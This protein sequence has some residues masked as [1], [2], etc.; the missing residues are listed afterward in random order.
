M[1]DL[2]FGRLAVQRGIITADQL[3]EALARRSERP[4][5]DLPTVLQQMKAIDGRTITMLLADIG[6]VASASA[7]GAAT[8]DPGTP[9]PEEARRAMGVPG[10]HLGRFVLEG[11]LGQGGMGVVYKAHD[12]VLHRPVAIK[13]LK[14]TDDA[15]DSQ[16]FFREARAA[17]ALSHANIVPVHEI[18]EH[19][20]RPFLV[21]KYID[22]RTL[23]R[24]RLPI[25]R[26]AEIARV[27]AE[28]LQ[29]AH[30]QG[31]VH[32][33]LKP[34][35]LML[36]RDGHVWLL[37]FGLAREMRRGAT[38]T[39]E[40]TV[41]GT[42]AYMSPEQAAG[43]RGDARSDLYM[44]GASLY[45]MLTGRLLFT[46]K[47]AL[48][49]LG[50]VAS[51]EPVPPR[52]RNAEIPR[53]LETIVLKCLEKL[54]ERRYADAGA[55]AEDLRRWAAGEPILAAPPSVGYRIRKWA[56]RRK[57]AVG[58]TATA[59]AVLTIAGGLLVPRWR[60]AERKA[61]EERRQKETI[62][63]YGEL[64]RRLD[65][66]KERFYRKDYRLT[67]QEFDRYEEL[68]RE[69]ARRMAPAGSS[70]GLWLIGR[71]RE[72]RGDLAGAEKAYEGA[73][74]IDSSH[75]ATL[76]SLGRLRVDRAFL[77]RAY[78][79]SD[80]RR[81]GR[82]LQKARDGVDLIRRGIRPTPGSGSFA[83]DLAATYLQLL[84]T[85]EH[86]PAFRADALMN[87]WKG[88]AHAE[89][90]L[91][92]EAMMGGEDP[93]V[94]LN[95]LI[96]LMP[97]N[98]KA[99]LARS[100]FQRDPASRAADL[101]RA[102]EINPRWVDAHVA[103][104]AF[105][106]DSEDL[107]GG[108]RDFTTALALDPRSSIA[109][110]NR[111]CARCDKREFEEA[112]E[113][114]DRAI[115][116]DP[117][118]SDAFCNRGLARTGRG[119]LEAA[120]ADYDQAIRIDP[121]DPIIWFNRAKTRSLRGDRAGALKDYDV[122]IEIDNRYVKAYVN[123][124]AT[125]DALGDREGALAD[126]ERALAIDPHDASALN[127]RGSIRFAQGDQKGALEDFDRA[128]EAH[129]G[130]PEA[131]V[132]RGNLRYSNGD[133]VRALADYD[134]AEEIGLRNPDL[135]LNRG[136]VRLANGDFDGA[137]SDCTRVLDA[138]PNDA[139][140]LLIRGA[141][142][143]LKDDFE[144]AIADF[145]RAIQLNPRDAEGWM[146]RGIMYLD[147]GDRPRAAQDFS[148]SLD[149]APPDWPHRAKVRKWLETINSR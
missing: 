79:D 139:A 2:A 70:R 106:V 60:Q 126:Y 96:D 42:P 142:R 81:A 47:S 80:R 11:E 135:Y 59:V 62:E 85:W 20:G 115:E 1:D 36:D 103:R 8:T 144:G 10:S 44:L 132:N 125:R 68:E 6:T 23:D 148:R 3:R 30:R 40:G 116:I 111:A 147:R 52:R 113:D 54:P 22:G 69:I 46:G 131:Y 82:A 9:P 43:G 109:Y 24:M 84:E 66:L 133:L 88:E 136:R 14:R 35:N 53:D 90:F 143:H 145:S 134:R 140:A 58:S 141:G 12:P 127:N 57:V 94:P 48:E 37:D 114:C 124:G 98:A 49:I 15:T 27:A 123:R 86:G 38:L 87:R 72:V 74:A 112:I 108:I 101:D 76:V 130:R 34:S 45:E 121:R 137:V 21:M 128:I 31:I 117:Q 146:R 78:A 149:L 100:H 91:L 13:L 5:A 95:R 51:A 120:L 61:D 67:D 119:E 26:A 25:R 97:S 39:V 50:K 33:D 105:R 102:I 71:S 75:D 107:D 83:H 63:A 93:L 28:A 64:E 18:G 17:T 56:G 99:Y 7:R 77:E 65:L 118:N 92:L 29:H 129:P 32:R 73:L 16:R 89:E 55:L 104:G 4:T 19:E 110:V 138:N 122:A 41:F